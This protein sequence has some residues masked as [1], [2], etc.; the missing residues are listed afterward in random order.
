LDS[1]KEVMVT[2]FLKAWSSPLEQALEFTM[3][4]LGPGVLP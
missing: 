3:Q 2:A 1:D 4:E